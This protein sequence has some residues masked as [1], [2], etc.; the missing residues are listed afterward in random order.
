MFKISTDFH[1]K[2]YRSL[3]RRAILKIPTRSKVSLNEKIKTFISDKDEFKLGK[4]LE[5]T[6]VRI[7]HLTCSVKKV[8][9]EISQIHRKTPA[10]E[11]L[12]S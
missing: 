1:I 3:K 11:S 10:P 5:S 2:T 8:F 12:F 6:N 4:S 7:S 9:L